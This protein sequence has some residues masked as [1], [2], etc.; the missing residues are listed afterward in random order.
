MSPDQ[1]SRRTA[2]S[3]GGALVGL[4]VVGA[5]AFEL[6]SETNETPGADGFTAGTAPA[7]SDPLVLVDTDGIAENNTAKAVTGT[8]L[9]AEQFGDLPDA[10][11]GAFENGSES[12]SAIDTDPVGKLVL[13]GSD[14]APDVGG[15]V[16][17]ADWTDDDLL[18]VFESSDETE[19]Q[20]ERYRSRTLYTA[21]GTSAAVLG[22]QEFALGATEVVRNVVD[23][24]HGDADPVGGETLRSFERT[25]RRAHVRFSF[26]ELRLACD[27]VAASRSAAYDRITQVY[28]S[29]P[30]TGGVVRLHLRVAPDGDRTDVATAL[31]NDLGVT[32]GDSSRGENAGLPHDA[33]DGVT[34]ESEHD[35][36]TV[37]YGSAGDRN[38]FASDVV[39][40]TVCL[41]GRTGS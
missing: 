4:G 5:S 25:S 26:D 10:L 31:R 3:A 33:V 17:W 21:G 28:G 7:G 19:T 22:D 35:F 23:A 40:T 20:T 11:V 41:T 12:R 13:V 2:L 9:G 27:G 8:L 37:E 15:A 16:V 36:V 38:G 1:L 29:V 34:V 39:E 18:D 14:V 30:A 24:W 32:G 6:T